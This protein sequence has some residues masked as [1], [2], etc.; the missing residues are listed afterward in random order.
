MRGP[1]AGYEFARRIGNV[2]HLKKTEGKPSG[3]GANAILQ[4]DRAAAEFDEAMKYILSF[5]QGGAVCDFS[6]TAPDYGSL[7]YL[8]TD[9]LE[10]AAYGYLRELDLLRDF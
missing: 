5:K 9:V 8:R 3:D 2:L 4:S 6:P 1:T 7:G 10:N